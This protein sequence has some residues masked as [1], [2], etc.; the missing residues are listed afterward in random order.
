MKRKLTLLF[1]MLTCAVLLAGCNVSLTKQNKNF[2]ES[3]LEKKTDDYLKKWLET[4]HKTQLEQYQAAIEYYD[5]QKDTM[6]DSE[7]EQYLSQREEAVKLIDQCTDALK[8]KKKFGT[9][10]K[11]KVATEFT[12]SS[13]LATVNETILS[14][15]GKK[16]IYSVSFD[17]D[18]NKTLEKIDEYKTMGQKMSRAGIN[19]IMSMGIVFC[20]LI[21]I[22]LVISCF[23]AI[24]WIGELNSKRQAKVKSEASESPA[25]SNVTPSGSDEN[26]VDDLELV[27]VI[28]AAIAAASENESADGFVVRSILRR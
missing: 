11:K 12:V 14:D 17:K 20:V 16:Y 1:C 13:S 28:T 25:A 18:G 8:N 26:L 3:K 27:A 24:G 5:N 6:S 4:D 10:I 7:L 2:K 15:T 19:T 21:F 22:S 23:K 9:K